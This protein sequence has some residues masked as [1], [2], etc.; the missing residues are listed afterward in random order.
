M[1]I[2]VAIVIF[3]ML[4]W[5]FLVAPARIDDALSAPFAGRMFAHRGLFTQDQRVPENSLVAFSL[6][7]EGGYGI[8]LDVQDHIRRRARRIP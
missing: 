8:E 2:A 4:L 1:L 5:G 3:L 7:A 6:A